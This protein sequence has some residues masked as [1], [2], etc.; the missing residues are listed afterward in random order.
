MGE[1][2]D[3]TEARILQAA[4]ELVQSG[5]FGAVTTRAVAERAGV[6]EVTLFRRFGSKERLMTA[7]VDRTL[8]EVDV[9]RLTAEREA[10]SLEDDLA[11]WARQ[12]LDHTLPMASILLLSLQESERNPALC[13]WH[14]LFRDRVP[15]ALAEHLRSRQGGD[16]SAG[17]LRDIAAA[18]YATLFAHVL[19]SHIGDPPDVEQLS[20]G[21]ARVF[22]RAVRGGSEDPVAAGH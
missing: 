3:T 17:P 7:M 22:A 10:V 20:R 15:E 18:F 2:R 16:P 19:S 5:G 21:I 1:E 11:A 13:P 4:R 8:E 14:T 6:N 9:R 12:Y